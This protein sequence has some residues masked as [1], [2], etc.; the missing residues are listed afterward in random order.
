MFSRAKNA[1]ICQDFRSKQKE[2]INQ[3]QK[4]KSIVILLQESWTIFNQLK[5]SCQPYST[6]QNPRKESAQTWLVLPAQEQRR[7]PRRHRPARGNPSPPLPQRSWSSSSPADD[8]GRYSNGR[9]QLRPAAGFHEPAT[10]SWGTR[11]ASPCA[12]AR[13]PGPSF[14]RRPNLRRFFFPTPPLSEKFRSFSFSRSP[15]P[16]FRR[17]WGPEISISMALIYNERII[18]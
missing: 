17:S 8:S 15:T 12:P 11:R 3:K 16:V 7:N 13:A 9:R 14:Y 6:N 5:Q 4:K 1:T 10:T 2:R 18:E